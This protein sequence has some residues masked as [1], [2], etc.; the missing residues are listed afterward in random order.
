MFTG[1]YLQFDATW[2]L[3]VGTHLATPRR[4]YSHHGI[5]VG[6]GR[7]IHYAGFARSYRAGPVEE[8]DL[9]GF[10]A[11]HPV[12][13]ID[14]HHRPYSAHQV[15][16]RARAR[17]GE[18]AYDLLRNNCEHFCNW[19]ISGLARSVQAERYGRWSALVLTCAVGLMRAA[20]ASRAV[21]A[22]TPG[23]GAS[24]H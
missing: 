3:P 4:R 11:G 7:V 9:P 18:Q 21:P 22:C 16:A 15:V 24:A 12:Q 14:H 1:H 19:C 2:E 23:R 6:H 5:Y 13:V 10:A 17:L 8:I 20:P